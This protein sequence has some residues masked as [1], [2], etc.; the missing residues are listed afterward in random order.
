[1]ATNSKKDKTEYEILL[2]ENILIGDEPEASVSAAILKRLNSMEA[3][4]ENTL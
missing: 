2:L 4:N 3:E 1:M